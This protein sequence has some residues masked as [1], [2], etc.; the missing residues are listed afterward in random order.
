MSDLEAA[1]IGGAGE[2]QPGAPRGRAAVAATDA[3]PGEG[4]RLFLAEAAAR[5][6][7][8]V[9]TLRRWATAGRL[10]TDSRSGVSHTYANWL[11]AALSAG[12]A[13]PGSRAAALARLETD[14]FLRL[15]QKPLRRVLRPDLEEVERA[16]RRG[17][18]SL[19]EPGG[20]SD[21]EPLI[22]LA[23]GFL[24]ATLPCLSDGERASRALALVAVALREDG[25]D[26]EYQVELAAIRAEPSPLGLRWRATEARVRA[27][28]PSGQGDPLPATALDLGTQLLA[29]WPGA[30]EPLLALWLERALLEG[31]RDLPS[32]PGA[33]EAVSTG[34][35]AEAAASVLLAAG[36][37]PPEPGE[38]PA[39]DPWLA[40]AV[41]QARRW[42]SAHPEWTEAETITNLRQCLM[43]GEGDLPWVI[44][45]QTAQVRRLAEQAMRVV[46]TDSPAP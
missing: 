7:V 6:G 41:E 17:L 18:R 19:V 35:A 38:R 33:A 46:N 20:H 26:G 43:L 36:G 29:E 16:I 30:A 4:E 40:I 39:P 45:S 44:R 23:E 3:G 32:H 14:Q 10:R 22:V 24:Q 8:A 12:P 2:V 28:L 31:A 37:T 27:T 42:R 11:G 9:Q 15:A 21:P 25:Y 5:S 1:G 34:I 13:A